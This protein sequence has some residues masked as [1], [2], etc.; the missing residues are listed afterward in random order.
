METVGVRELKARVSEIVDAVQS[1]GKRY[2]ITKRG[3]PVA[4]I[5]PARTSALD[6]DDDD[7]DHDEAVWADMDELAREIGK[8]WPKGVSAVEALSAD[9]R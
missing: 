3:K 8:R 1:Q 2:R 5:V 4:L 6:A 9:R 7:L